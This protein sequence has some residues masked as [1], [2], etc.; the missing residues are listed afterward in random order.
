MKLPFNISRR[1]WIIIIV[2]LV[3]V[4]VWAILRFFILHYD[5]VRLLVIALFEPYLLLTERLSNYFLSITCP[6]T[7]IINHTIFCQNTRLNS[8]DSGVLFKKWILLII[9]LYWIIRSPLKEKLLFTVIIII[10]HFIIVSVDNAI[11]ADIVVNGYDE[12]S[13]P[14]ISRTPGLLALITFLTIWILRY[15]TI[16]LNSLEKL[17]LNT[18]LVD[19]KIPELIIVMYFYVI[20]NN[21]LYGFFDLH[22]WRN[23]MITTV[24]KILTLLGYD[25]VI[26]GHY[27]VGNYGTV[28]IDRGCVGY[29]SMLKFAVVVFLTGVN[30]LRRWSFIIS[31][32]L[33][34]EIISGLRLIMIFIWYENYGFERAMHF[35]NFSKDA[36]HIIIFILWI[37]WFEF[38]TD[39]RPKQGKWKRKIYALFV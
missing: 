30:N 3:L 24:H 35:H 8:F 17:K 13:L 15:R 22:I 7:E 36:V 9:L 31:G 37:I 21:F 26:E 6:G 33:F 25:S 20:V 14:K 2:I 39:I 29:N 28:F 4:F 38:F 34:L 23:L 18:K 1:T 10:T 27:I 32:A 19:S 11:L 12:E 16:I 5:P